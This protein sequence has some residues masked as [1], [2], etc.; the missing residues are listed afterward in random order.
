MWKMM[1]TTLLTKSATT[2]AL[3]EHVLSSD[4]PPI[5]LWVVVPAH[6]FY[7][8]GSPM[9]EQIQGDTNGP[10]KSSDQVASSHGPE[11]ANPVGGLSTD[12][13]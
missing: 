10:D 6:Q 7:S 11:E 4:V 8:N 5:N 1:R 2:I 9:D 13:G 12:R 3:Q